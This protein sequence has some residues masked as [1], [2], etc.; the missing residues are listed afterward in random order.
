[1]NRNAIRALVIAAGV[2]ASIPLAGQ[3]VDNGRAVYEKWCA[4]C[5][6]DTGAGDGE[7]AHY[8][9]PRPRDFTRAVYQVRTT[10]SGELPTDEDLRRVIDNGMPGTTM[11]GWRS[12]LGAQQRDDVIAYIKTFSRFFDGTAPTRIEMGRKPGLSDEG[13]AEGKR[14]FEDELECLRCHGPQGRGDGN[15]APTLT[16]DWDMPIR[17]AD[18]TKPWRFNGGGTVEDIYRTMRTGLDGTPMPSFSDV[19][20]AGI[21][22]D[23]QLWQT[24]QYVRSLSAEDTPRARDVIRAS[25]AE[26][27]L[28]LGAE[29]VA[30][31]DVELFYIPLVGQITISP[32]WFVPSADG[33]WVQ[34]VHNG[35]QLA[36]RLTW[37]DPTRS[38]DPVWDDYFQRIVGAMAAPDAPHLEQQG[39]DLLT[40]QFPLNLPEGMERPYFLGGDSRRPVYALQWSSANDQI[41][42]G[43]ARSLASFVAESGPSLSHSSAFDAGR[44]RVQFTRPL[45]VGD[46]STALSLVEGQPIPI[47]FGVADGSNGEDVTRRAISAWYA[48]YLDVPTP[49]RVY[50]APIVAGLLTVGLGIVVV[51]RAQH[52]ERGA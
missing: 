48:I 26:G 31:D 36:V 16:D 42:Q 40:V 52:S 8:M 23:E 28:P 51:L 18:L 1:M 45:S 50:V 38:P 25:I 39:P 34:A 29:D 30:W 43:T 47:A 44:W 4:G 3:N 21:I 27:P 33:I 22:T 9:L 19:I 15:S 11:P 5:H 12:K 32:R 14:L 7:A 13:L 49:A 6:G 17:A 10:A 41:E 35:E 46:P 2:T 37:N 20:D 24:A